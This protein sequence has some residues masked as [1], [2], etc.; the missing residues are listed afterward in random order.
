MLRE[1]SFARLLF[2]IL[3]AGAA[4]ADACALVGLT[5]QTNASV[6]SW[7][8]MIPLVQLIVLGPLATHAA[9]LLGRPIAR[10]TQAADSL[11]PDLAPR[12]LPEE[13]PKEVVAAIRAFKT[14]QQRLA[15][16]TAERIEILAAI[17]HD[18]Q[19]PI[20]RMRLRAEMLESEQDSARLL[21]D[22]DR[23]HALVKEGVTYARTLH[24]ITEPPLRI[25]LRALL[26]SLVADYE[27]AGHDLQLDAR[28]A[29]PVVTLPNA[30]RRILINLLDN[31]LKFGTTVSIRARHDN[32]VLVI[33]ILDDGPGI[34]PHQLEDVFKPFFRARAHDRKDTAGSGLGLAIARQLAIAMNAEVILR[35]RLEGGLEARL[36]LRHPSTTSQPRPA[37][38]H[39]RSV[40]TNKSEAV[41]RYI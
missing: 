30:L 13:G 29:E 24:G 31:A 23:M 19:T 40:S 41:Q 27:D 36:T 9:R 15:R 38:V 8:A 35:N 7:M 39:H 26:E 22:V 1:L 5:L 33:A 6:P 34:D 37:P 3:A 4:L 20:T 16:C 12:E 32:A 14:M 28:I 17:S 10:L 18:L 21:Q 25:D 11:G 2:G